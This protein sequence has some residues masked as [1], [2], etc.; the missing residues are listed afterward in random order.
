MND[1]LPENYTA[2]VKQSNYFKLQDGSNRIRIMSPAVVGYQ[3]WDNRKPVNTP[4]RRPSLDESKPAKHFWAVIVWNYATN[5]FQCRQITQ[6]SIMEQIETYNADVDFWN[7]RGYDLK[8]N[9]SG[10]DLET[11]Y[12]VTPWKIVEVEKTIADKFA[13]LDYDLNNLF[14]NEE[15]II[16][17][18]DL[19]FK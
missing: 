8:I 16:G 18:K 4:D 15:V 11:K 2:P 1:F 6:K 5:S 10:K 9:R 7:P 17:E 14:I 3:D 12:S 19:P 13:K